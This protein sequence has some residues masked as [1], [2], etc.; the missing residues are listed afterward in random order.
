MFGRFVCSF[1][2]NT[3]KA[4]N[5]TERGNKKRKMIAETILCII[6][7]AILAMGI[8]LIVISKQKDGIFTST[9]SKKPV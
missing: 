4:I 9:I 1:L 2:A 7:A 6:M 5:G 8:Y 3:L